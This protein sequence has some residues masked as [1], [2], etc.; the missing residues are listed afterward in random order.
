[1][2]TLFLI[3][4]GFCATMSVI[5]SFTAFGDAVD[6]D[7]KRNIFLLAGLFALWSIITLLAAQSA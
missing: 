6:N 4:A 1:M 5:G 7:G 2:E 3:A